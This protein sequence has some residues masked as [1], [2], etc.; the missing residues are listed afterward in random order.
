MFSSLHQVIKCDQKLLVK[1][2]FFF[3]NNIYYNICSKSPKG[4]S[5]ELTLFTFE[6]FKNTN[7]LHDRTHTQEKAKE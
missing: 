1:Q 3:M 7:A 2:R 5:R 4:S 6:Y